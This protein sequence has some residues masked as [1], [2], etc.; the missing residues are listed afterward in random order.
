M[1]VT[2]FLTGFFI[3]AG[4]QF[5]DHISGTAPWQKDRTQTRTGALIIR[6]D[7]FPFLSISNQERTIIWKKR[8]T[9]IKPSTKTAALLF[10]TTVRQNCRR[11]PWPSVPVRLL[12]DLAAATTAHEVFPVNYSTTWQRRL[13]KNDK[14]D[15]FAGVWYND[16]KQ[17]C[18]GRLPA[19]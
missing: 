14:G 2:I 4:F 11:S 17:S 7:S 16:Y 18:I 15:K 1:L 10:T 19:D 12:T 6:F 8:K 5:V 3:L 13:T 9:R